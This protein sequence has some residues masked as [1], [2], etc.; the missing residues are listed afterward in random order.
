MTNAPTYE[1]NM[2]SA[3]E[4][5]YIAY[6]TYFSH[7]PYLE[8]R[9]SPEITLI[10]SKEIAL[11]NVVLQTHLAP[12]H[13]TAA[14][15]ATLSTFG[16]LNQPLIWHILPSTQPANLEHALKKHDFLPF[17]DEPH[18]VIEPAAHTL[19][20][21]HIPGFIIERVTNTASFARWHEATVAGFFP[22]TPSL[23]GKCPEE[24]IC[25]RDAQRDAP[26]KRSG[27]E[28]F[29]MTSITST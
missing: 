15:E 27:S 25:P 4:A 12:Q 6:Y 21:P 10:M 2:I 7:L 28:M 9:Q 19:H 14:I 5:N 1:A 16:L 26:L 13:V 24:W 22:Q 20:V 8:L 17:E 18:M 23:G 29:F 3:M 11:W